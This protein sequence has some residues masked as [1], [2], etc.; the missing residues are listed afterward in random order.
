MPQA[1]D[2]AELAGQSACV[3]QSSC[4][5]TDGACTLTTHLCFNATHTECTTT[6][7]QTCYWEEECEADTCMKTCQAEASECVGSCRAAGACLLHQLDACGKTQECLAE[8]WLLPETPED[9][10]AFGNLTNCFLECKSADCPLQ[11]KVSPNSPCRALQCES[12]YNPDCI[13]SIASYCVGIGRS[14]NDT[15]C[16]YTLETMAQVSD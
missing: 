14:A 15:F 6:H 2:C 10:W 12:M 16:L 3:Q 5:W 13:M 4:Q 9:T 8:C 7:S 1:D 11:D